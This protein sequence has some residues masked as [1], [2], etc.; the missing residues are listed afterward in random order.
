MGAERTDCEVLVGG[1]QT[2]PLPAAIDRIQ[3]STATRNVCKTL[4]AAKKAEP[5]VEFDDLQ[6][7]KMKAALY[8]QCIGMLLS[9]ALSSVESIQT[10]DIPALMNHIGQ[11]L[12]F[13]LTH[14]EM[15]KAPDSERRQEVLVIHNLSSIFENVENLQE[16]RIMELI[17]EHSICPSLIKSTIEYHQFY[18]QATKICAA[19]ALAGIFA[20]EAY[21][22]SPVSFVPSAE[23][24]RMVVDLE[25]AFLKEMF[26][27]VASRKKTWALFDNIGRFRYQI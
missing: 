17:Q 3:N 14:P 13:S 2:Q 5:H 15:V 4:V 19:Q 7:I 24:K 8:E 10:L 11:T 21:K 22:T 20:T 23:I 9:C 18:S 6:T 12:N 1:R 27:D 16:D 25:P 26:P